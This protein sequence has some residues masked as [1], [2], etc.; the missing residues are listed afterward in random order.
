MTNDSLLFC[1]PIMPKNAGNRRRLSRIFLFIF[2]CLLTVIF[3]L[4]W[5]T[6]E[7]EKPKP[8]PQ[9]WE[10]KGIVAALADP[11]AGVRENAA[12]KLE[13]YKLDDLKKQIPNYQDVVNL[14]VKQLSPP[15]KEEKD[16]K[17]LSRRAAAYALG[18]MQA[19]DFAANVAALLK[20]S[21]TS[22][23]YYAASALGQMQAKDFAA[24]V[25]ALLKDSDTSVRRAA[26][27]ALG[28][29]Q[30]KDFAAN[31]TALLK[32]SDTSV[33]RVA[34]S[35]LGQMQAKDF[36]ANVTALLKDSNSDVR[37]VA[38][39]ALGQMQAKDFAANVT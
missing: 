32:D 39:S 30:A 6:A 21:D 7:E 8:K 36:A 11:Y 26:A 34:A 4:T 9:D 31:V 2:T 3:S 15:E 37:R 13:E 14:L 38:A 17:S 35:A 5:V 12:S 18:Q 24:N 1:L 28:Q 27:S 25:A 19:K 22:V 23:R 33:R 16:E 20:D 29:M 10:I